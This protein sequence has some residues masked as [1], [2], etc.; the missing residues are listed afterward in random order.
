[1]KTTEPLEITTRETVEWRKTFCDYPATLWTLQYRYRGI[2]TGF[3]VSGVADGTAFL[4]TVLGTT[5]DG[6]TAGAYEWQAWVTEIADATNVIMVA[7]GDV[8]VIAGFDPNALTAIETRSPNKIM[9]DTLDL[10]LKNTGDLLQYEMET[11][12]G[13]KMVRRQLRGEVMNLR[14]YYAG[15]VSLEETRKRIKNGGPFMK[16]VGVRFTDV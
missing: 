4:V 1:M 5:T 9:L 10:A 8:T 2:G 3:N 11:P 14:K 13:R 12:T 15:L 16:Q 7:S 6:M